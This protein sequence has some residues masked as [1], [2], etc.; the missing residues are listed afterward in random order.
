[1]DDDWVRQEVEYALKS[2]IPLLPVLVGGA[3]PLN[4][5]SLPASIS[6]LATVQGR[7]ITDKRDIDFL[8]TH[9]VEHYGFERLKTELDFPTP[10]DRSPGLPEKDVQ[11]ALQRL[12]GW[13]LEERDSD[14]GKDGIAI[15]LVSTL[16][17]RTFEDVIHSWQQRRGMFL[18]LTIILSGRIS[19][20]ICESESPRGILGYESPPKTSGS[21]NTFKGF[22]VTTL[23][24]NRGTHQGMPPNNCL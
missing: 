17:F 15:E 3:Q 6:A 24:R 14:R 8:I 2:G 11:D 21:R 20:R 7:G 9:L 5:Q 12:P 16:K 18:L 22:T 23:L 10:V 4:S 13:R 19:T 1:L